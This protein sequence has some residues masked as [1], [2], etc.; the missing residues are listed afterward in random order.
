MEHN[1]APRNKPKLFGQLEKKTKTNKWAEDLNRNFSKTKIHK[2]KQHMNRLLN[3]TNH[4]ENANEIT[5]R[6]HF[7]SIR[8]AVIEKTMNSK[9]W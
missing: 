4:Q 8:M 7:T 6:Y 1:R 2:T 3:I 9:C 5:M